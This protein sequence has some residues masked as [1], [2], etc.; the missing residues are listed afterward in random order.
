MRHPGRRVSL[1]RSQVELKELSG[2]TKSNRRFSSGETLEEVVV[3]TR[4]TYSVLYRE[5][6]KLVLMH[7]TTF[8]QVEVDLAL[9]GDHDVMVQEG[10]EVMLEFHDSSPI[11]LNLPNSGVYKVVVRFQR[12]SFWLVAF[13][14]LPSPVRSR[15]VALRSLRSRI[16]RRRR[17]RSGTTRETRARVER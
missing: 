3:D 15:R 16:E 14:S 5:A 8:E 10:M 2:T 17:R 9:V 4:E 1:V 7:K 11:K 12:P 13:D 6:E